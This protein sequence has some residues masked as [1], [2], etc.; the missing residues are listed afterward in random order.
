MKVSWG[1]SEMVP[2]IAALGVLFLLAAVNQ[3]LPGEKG[4]LTRRELLA[5]YVILTIGAP[6]VSR[7]VMLWFLSCSLGQ[8]YY[9]HTAPI[10]ETTFVRYVPSWFHPGNLAAIEGFFQGD[11]SVMWSSWQTPLLSWGSFFA[12]LFVANLCLMLLFRQQWVTNERLSFP[13]AQV[14]L[15][16]VRDS[17]DGKARLPAGS[18]FWIG[19]GVVLLLHLQY[20]LPAIFP[21]LPSISLGEYRLVASEKVGPLTGVGDIWLILY[22]WCIGLAYLIPKELSFS[23]WFFWIIR[24]IFTVLAITAG[25][26]P[27]KP[28]DWSGATFP[29]PYYQGGGAVI[30]LMI[31][32]LW[33]SRR[34]VA[35]ALRSALRGESEGGPERPLPYRWAL[36]GLLVSL[37]YLVLFCRAA[38]SRTIVALILVG[39]IL[40]YHVVW[41]RLRAENG[42]SFIG[43]PFAVSD[44]MLSPF[45]TVLYRPAEIVTITATRWAYVPGWGESC[46]V[47]TGSSMDALKISD[48]AG[49]RQKP[50]LLAMLG[51]FLFALALGVFV[52][53]TGVYHYGFYA[54]LPAEGWLEQSVRNAGAQ[55]HEAIS[56]PT[57]LN[58]AGIIA[59]SAGMGVTFLLGELRLRFWWWPL[60]PVGYLAA[61]VWGSQWWYMPLFIGWLL[62][63]L[64]IRYG[65]LRLYQKTVPLAIGVIV[66]DRLSEI[67]WADALWPVRAQG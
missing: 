26:T 46:E 34:Q 30:A 8:Q 9:I 21:S 25:A 33:G 44:I 23:V 36:L 55:M 35:W 3:L 28:E 6:L 10:W 61:N 39:L 41:A 14:P 16:T 60:H 1:F 18:M 19:F 24:V 45:G 27:Q 50:L 49:I 53:L 58:L 56:N 20:R 22:P 31:L 54:I 32:A 43:F 17:P 66:G 57:R 12:A 37:G 65:G 5:I 7:G 38:G 62:K 2:P 42:M 13:I 59:L 40:S 52:E 15:V 4:K 47:I 63:S 48:S 67:L 64:T 51:C 29:A 11:A